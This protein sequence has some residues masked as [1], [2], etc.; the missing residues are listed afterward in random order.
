MS[1]QYT[2][3]WKDVLQNLS[4]KSVQGNFQELPELLS[5]FNDLYL[6]KVTFSLTPDTA[7]V[8]LKDS[9]GKV[10]GK[11]T[12][13]K[14]HLKEG[15]YSYSVSADH[16]TA[17][18]NQS[19]TITNSDETTGTKTVSVSLDRKD[20]AVT[21]TL[22]PETAT[23]VV[24]DSEAHTIEADNGVYY[25]EAGSYTWSASAEGYTAQENQSLTISAGDVTT[26]T[27]SVSVTLVEA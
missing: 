3:I 26:G 15:T 9:G 4:G 24:K 7:T 17:K 22:S 27:K 20:C 18:E 1:I 2:D 19:L 16:Y 13:G 25:L 23:L 6:C 10:I 5:A 8:V 14:Y 11:S 21:F 12:D